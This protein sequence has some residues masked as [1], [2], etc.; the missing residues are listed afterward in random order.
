MLRTDAADNLEE[1]LPWDSGVSCV[2][3]SRGLSDN[4]FPAG[5]F[6]ESPSQRGALAGC[7]VCVRVCVCTRVLRGHWEPR[8]TSRQTP[9][10]DLE[11]TA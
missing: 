7:G 6:P 1:N 3:G 10:R 2:K 4:T 11:S 5:A 9:S 8:G